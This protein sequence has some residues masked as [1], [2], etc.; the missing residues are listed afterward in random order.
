[1]A[2]FSANGAPHT[3]LGQPPQGT[4]RQTFQRAENPLHQASTK[5]GNVLMI[6]KFFEKQKAERSALIRVAADVSPL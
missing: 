5:P 4:K 1:L 3:S 6:R 2:L